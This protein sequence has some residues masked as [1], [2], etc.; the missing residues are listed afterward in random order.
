LNIINKLIKNIFNKIGFDIRRINKEVSNINFDDL[1][2][3]KIISDP[4]IFDV[5]GE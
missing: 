4:I 3:D 2:K 5:G 1:I